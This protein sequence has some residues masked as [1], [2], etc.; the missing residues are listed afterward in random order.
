MAMGGAHIA[1]ADDDAT[2][3]MNPAGLRG[4]RSFDLLNID[5]GRDVLG[6]GPAPSGL[7]WIPDYIDTL[8]PTA[9][10]RHHFVFHF[11]VGAAGGW[12]ALIATVGGAINDFNDS[13][14][15]NDGDRRLSGAAETLGAISTGGGQLPLVSRRI[16]GGF[17]AA[18]P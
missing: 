3:F 12:D 16:K 18:I 10:Q 15:G 1:V 5:S 8:T 13:Q 4:T 9:N 6:N 17:C 11:F 2:L 7:G 14:T